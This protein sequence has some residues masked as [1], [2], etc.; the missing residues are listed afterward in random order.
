MVWG[1]TQHEHDN[2]CCCCCHSC[3]ASSKA[4]NSTDNALIYKATLAM[5]HSN[6]LLK[7]GVITLYHHPPENQ[8]FLHAQLLLCVIK[9][10]TVCVI[11]TIFSISPPRHL[12]LLFFRP[13]IIIRNPPCHPNRTTH[14]VLAGSTSSYVAMRVG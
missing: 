12:S 14:L 3:D 6:F 5:Y 13:L 1:D 2:G 4:M 11:T 9:P 7:R 10:S 8:T